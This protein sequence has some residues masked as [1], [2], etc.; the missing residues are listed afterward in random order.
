MD[1]LNNRIDIVEKRINKLE[2]RLATR[3]EEIEHT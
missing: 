1:G 2:K 3:D